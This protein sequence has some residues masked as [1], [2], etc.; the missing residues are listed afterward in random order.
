MLF[1]FITNCIAFCKKMT[2]V[3]LF[4][5]PIVILGKIWYNYNEKV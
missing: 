2:L 3:F 1:D 5:I 4:A